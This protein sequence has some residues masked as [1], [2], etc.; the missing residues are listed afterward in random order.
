L[1][2]FF[3]SICVAVDIIKGFG[4]NYDYSHIWTMSV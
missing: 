1:G 4:L 2:V 3:F